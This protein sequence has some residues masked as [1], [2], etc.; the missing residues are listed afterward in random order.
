MAKKTGVIKLAGWN[1]LPIMRGLINDKEAY[2]IM[3]SGASISVM[4]SNGAEE[5]EFNVEETEDGAAAGYGGAASF[6]KAGA[7]KIKTQDKIELWV[8]EFKAQDL[9]KIVDVIN[10]NEGFKINGILGFDLMKRYSFILN[11]K[12]NTM[13]FTY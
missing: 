4:D 2:F 11:F 7:I 13:S 3:D 9:S 12:D 8:P 1:K 6:K 5:F 10:R